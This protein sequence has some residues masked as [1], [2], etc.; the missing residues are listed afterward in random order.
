MLR[1][2]KVDED[3]SEPLIGRP[4]IVAASANSAIKQSKELEHVNICI[5]K[6]AHDVDVETEDQTMTVT[7]R[8]SSEIV[9]EAPPANVTTS[10]PAGQ[11]STISKEISEELV[12]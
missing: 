3:S 11:G 12:D 8:V 4:P 1:A 5:E 6:T 7:K 10:A 2:V 9:T